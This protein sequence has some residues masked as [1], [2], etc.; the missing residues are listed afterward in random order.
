MSVRFTMNGRSI[1]PGDVKKEL[2]KAAEETFTKGIEEQM[3]ARL[4]AVRCDDHPSHRFT[5]DVTPV[6]LDKRDSSVKIRGCCEAGLA[7]A[8]ATVAQQR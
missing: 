8:K 5:V 6:K 1:R 7:R 2:T 3:N 4:R